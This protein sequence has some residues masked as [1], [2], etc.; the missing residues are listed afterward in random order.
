VP[1]EADD[2]PPGTGPSVIARRKRA[3]PKG[4]PLSP[5]GHSSPGWRRHSTAAL[6][7]IF[8]FAVSVAAAAVAKRGE[9]DR[10]REAFERRA[11]GLAAVVARNFQMTREVVLSLPT[12][13]EAS[14]A[15]EQHEFKTFVRPALER[16]PSLAAL[17]WAPLVRDEDRA[18]FEEKIRS[19]GYSSF[20]IREPDAT[21]KMVRSPKRPMYLPLTFLEPAVEAVRGLEV[22]FEPHRAK[23][24]QAAIDQ[25]QM[26]VS[27][28]FRLVEDPEGVQSVAVYAPAYDPIRPLSTAAE[29]RSSLL[30]MGIALFRLRPL[31]EGALSRE[32]RDGIALALIDPT[33]PNDLQLLYE[34]EPGVAARAHGSNMSHRESFEFG[35]RQYTVLTVTEEPE[36][37]TQ[38]LVF[39][40]GVGLT[41]IATAVYFTFAMLRRLRR[42]VQRSINLGQYTLEE[43]IGEGGMGVVYRATHALLRRPAAI[44]LLLKETASENELV[45]FER[46]V[47]LTSRLAHPNTISIFD[48]GRTADG[49]FYYVMEY[50]DGVDLERLVRADGPLDP[51]RAIHVL[52]QVAGALAE[53]HLSGLIHRDIKPANIVLTERLD[54]PDVVK[55]VDF[56]LVKT[57]EQASGDIGITQVNSITGTPLY[58][59]PEA[60]QSPQNVDG[61]ADIYALGAVAYFILTGDHV[62]DGSTVVQVLT[63]H[64]LEQ[65]TPPSARLGRPIEKD[66]EAVILS[67]LAKD[68]SQRP[69]SAAAVRDALLA[70]ADAGRYD[71]DAARSWWRERGAVLRTTARLQPQGAQHA[72]TMKVNVFDRPLADT[73][74][75]STP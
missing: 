60:I 28:R 34:T 46:E 61:R 68:R 75:I 9:N 53:A 73:A 2:K 58:L 4:S 18:F 14:I 50:L 39:L 72:T 70:C 57:V 26:H 25:G 27:L 30:G 67:C 35:N 1:P 11:S 52:A 24:I 33:A 54:E 20:E 13:F 56:G 51:G 63:R 23:D 69:A 10:N 55:V 62:F 43:K 37:Y 74:P 64:M 59:A 66:L 31:M 48:Y 17:E 3:A 32:R 29:R 16:H 21:G 71:A 38:W 65:P 19:Q 36:T 45:R 7:A 42:S 49:V 40:F 41:G 5:P 47:Q 22:M 12:F 8:G 6:I 44:K 15:V